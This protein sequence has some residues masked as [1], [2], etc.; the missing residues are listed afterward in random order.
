MVKRERRA[1]AWAWDKRHQRWCRAAERQSGRAAERHHCWFFTGSQEFW[2]KSNE[3]TESLHQVLQWANIFFH[4]LQLSGPP[5]LVG[6]IVGVSM[7]VS[8]DQRPNQN[9][10]STDTNFLALVCLI[11]NL[12]EEVPFHTLLTSKLHTEKKEKACHPWCL[13]WCSRRPSSDYLSLQNDPIFTQ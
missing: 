7:C 1:H 2:A 11:R 9:F 3:R 12:K 6:T 10:N 13:Y 5:G 8:H 4:I